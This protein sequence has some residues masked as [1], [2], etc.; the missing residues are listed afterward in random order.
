[1]RFGTDQKEDKKKPK[2][3]DIDISDLV[4][5]ERGERKAPETVESKVTKREKLDKKRKIEEYLDQ[6]LPLNVQC[7]DAINLTSS[8]LHRYFDIE[9]CRRQRSA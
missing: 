6:H 5:E 9:K 7:S 3:D 8:H 4:E 1:M 2:F